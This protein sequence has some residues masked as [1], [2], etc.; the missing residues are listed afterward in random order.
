MISEKIKDAK[1]VS[2]SNYVY[3]LVNDMDMVKIGITDSPYDRFTTIQNASGSLIKQFYLSDPISNN[4]EIEQYLHKHFKKYNT[5]AE[6]YRNISF[7]DVVDF[8]SKYIKENGNKINS[9][10]YVIVKKEN[11]N[12]I[13]IDEY[14]DIFSK[15]ISFGRL[16][17]IDIANDDNF[18][19]KLDDM[20]FE[21]ES[22]LYSDKDKIDKALGLAS[23]DI[24]LKKAIFLLLEKCGTKNILDNQIYFNFFKKYYNVEKASNLKSLK[25]VEILC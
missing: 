11:K 4:Y 2:K 19:S 25:N 22:I 3:V 17:N 18:I 20:I 13:D 10:I 6:W 21:Y 9:A 14:V 24:A 12:I 16:M 23:C 5:V 8:V 15:M 7:N 1:K